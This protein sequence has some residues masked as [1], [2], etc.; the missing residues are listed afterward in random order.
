MVKLNGLLICV[1]KE[2]VRMVIE[3]LPAHIE[4]THQEEGCISFEVKQSL[5]PF[6]WEVQEVFDSMKSFKHHQSRTASSI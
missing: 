3:L 5:D 4:L 6:I 1:S 2:E